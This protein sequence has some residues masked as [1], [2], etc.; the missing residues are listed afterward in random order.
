M[1]TSQD[2]ERAGYDPSVNAPPAAPEKA[3]LFE[4]FVD[5][6]YAPST[7]Y[8]R[9]ATSGYWPYFFIVW[10]L[11]AVFAFAGRAVT[12]AVFNA[13][14]S[15]NIA[16]AMEQNP[17]LTADMVAQQRGMMEGISNIG[18]YF[19]APL[20]I[21]FAAVLIWLGAKLVSASVSFDRAMLISAIAQIPRLLGSVLT[22]AQG[23]LMDT[24][25]ID[26]MHDVGYS[27]ARF[28]D[29]DAL[30]PQILGFIARFDVF[31]LWTT[32]L[33]GIG[34]AVIAKVPRGKGYAAAAIA[35]LIPGL[36][37]LMSLLWS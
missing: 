37:G 28:L 6:F 17:Q 5:V 18:V 4:D 20:L 35:W 31:T 19:A 16:R 21:F 13:E 10:A 23:L 26:S 11:M 9:R 32:V 2:T 15:R 24:T 36:F 3:S 1:T 25:T 29:Q 7:V 34:V 8:A 12:S 30:S 33:L 14:Y 22:T 27:P